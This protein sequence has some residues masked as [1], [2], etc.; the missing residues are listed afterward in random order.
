MSEKTLSIIIVVCVFFFC[1]FCFRIF[2]VLFEP[3]KIANKKT[4]RRLVARHYGKDARMPMFTT[5][6][7]CTLKIVIILT[8]AAAR[9]AWEKSFVGFCRFL[10]GNG[11]CSF[12]LR[13][14][15]EMSRAWN[16]MTVGA[17]NNDIILSI[18][19]SLRCTMG[20][21]SWTAFFPFCEWILNAIWITS[22]QPR[23]KC[24]EKQREITL[25]EEKRFFRFRTSESLQRIFL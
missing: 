4:H 7:A 3:K 21:C 12:A 20:Y 2:F 18:Y 17:Y 1:C 25:I 9:R 10:C 13:P 24:G 11:S 14:V 19:S 15:I 22:S 6:C 8:S 23:K 5:R 16:W